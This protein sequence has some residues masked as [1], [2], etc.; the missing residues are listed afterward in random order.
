MDIE[1]LQ[2]FVA[3][4][5]RGHFTTVAK[6]RSLDPSAVSRAIASLEHELGVRLFQRT[7]RTIKMTEAGHR[8][9]S[10]VE[11]LLEDLEQA[12]GD[13]VQN[14]ASPSGLLRLTASVAFG[15]SVLT[16]LLPE[17]RTRFPALGLEGIFT[18]SNLDLVAERIDLAVRLA[19]SLEGQWVVT[20][21]MDT[22]YRVVASPGYVKRAGRPK[23]PAALAQHECLRLSL[24]GFR[25]RWLFRNQRG[26]TQTVEVR[27]DLILSSVLSLKDTA[28]AGMGPTLLPHWLIDAEI[29]AGRLIDLFPNFRVTATTFETAAWLL[30]PSRSY[31]PAKVRVTIDFLKEKLSGRNRR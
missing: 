27:G 11:P 17:F 21:L 10:R 24:K 8:Y 14:S 31:L 29:A 12:R 9:L 1:A 19:P 25:T 30:Y 20:K 22:R 3:V 15:Q 23:N 2:L 4:A 18:D 28:I 13:A 16:P 26:A 7:T 5:Q 6:E